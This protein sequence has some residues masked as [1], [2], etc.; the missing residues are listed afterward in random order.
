MI[1]LRHKYNLSSFINQYTGYLT[2]IAIRLSR[3]DFYLCPMNILLLGSG[4]RE[5]AMAW[6]ISQSPQCD[7]LFIAPGNPGTMQCGEN[8]DIAATDFERIADLC[9]QKNISMLVVGPE[10]PLVKGVVDFFQGDERL[11]NIQV[12]GP[13]KTAAQLE[14]SKVFAKAFMQ[15]NGV[16]TPG[17][18]EFSKDDLIDAMQYVKG[19][20][21]PIVL[22]ADGLAAGKGV[23]I[24]NSNVEAENELKLMLSGKFGEAGNKVVV[25]EFLT[26]IE[27]TVIILTDGDSYLILLPSKDYKKVGDGDKGLNTGGMGAVSPPPF[28]T[29][30]FLAKIEEKIIRPTMDGLKKEG[31]RYKGFLYFGLFNCN[32]EPY[33]IEFN[34]RMGDPETQVIMPRIKNDIIELFNAVATNTLSTQT[35]AIEERPCATVILASR[36][37]PGEFDKGFVITGIEN[38]EHAFVFHAGTRINLNKE[39]T[40]SGGRV[41]AV[42][43]LGKSIED[44]LSNCYMNAGRIYFESRYFRRDIGWDLI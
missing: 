39:L 33:L 23:V 27:L 40:T 26:G 9:L 14:G 37:Y 4:G 6:K 15:R 3:Y 7:K 29:K 18:K 30:E 34:A 42:T 11:A 17:Y 41:L 12:I 35:L 31:I 1:F 24:C 36:G 5:H 13:N 38:C 32:N 20:S 19:H 25:E 10:D 43:S 2:H 21:L 8:I 28:A 44:A 22:K 16:A